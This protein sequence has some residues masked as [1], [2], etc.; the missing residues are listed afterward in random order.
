MSF[1]SDLLSKFKGLKF[2]TSYIL[3]HKEAVWVSTK[4]PEFLLNS[5]PELNIVLTKRVELFNNG[6]L[7]F[8]TNDGELLTEHPAIDLLNNP[9]ALQNRN[10]FFS[11]YLLNLDL[12][13]NSFIYQNKGT[14]ATLPQSLWVLNSSDLQ[15][16][17][18][19][20]LYQQ[21]DLDGIIEKNNTG[22]ADFEI[23]SRMRELWEKKDYGPYATDGDLRICFLGS[24][25]T[26]GG[27]SGS[28]V[29]NA[30]GHLVGI[31]FDR[32]KI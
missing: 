9:N 2:S 31:N 19:G 27:N 4:E 21:T 22:N 26:T 32:S 11:M 12:H 15:I 18:T 24:N 30:E 25:H 14:L 13:G 28:P 23:P 7:K 3:G 1:Y 17:I 5:I 6:E 10:D 16:N 8:L 20:K 29:I